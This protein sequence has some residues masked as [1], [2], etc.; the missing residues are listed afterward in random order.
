M[1]H[2]LKYMSGKLI[3]LVDIDHKRLVKKL[4]GARSFFFSVTHMLMMFISIFSRLFTDLF[5]FELCLNP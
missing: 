5:S 2:V 4:I 3:I 1:R